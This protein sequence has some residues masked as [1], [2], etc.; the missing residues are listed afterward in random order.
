VALISVLLPFR[1]AAPT[2]PSALRSLRRQTHRQLEVVAV[3]DGSS[4]EG[5]DLVR[6]MARADSRLRLIRGRGVGLPAALNLG[7]ECCRG[8]FVARM[9]ADDISCARRLA[10]QLQFLEHHSR[11]AAA[12]CLVRMVPGQLIT[13]GMRRYEAWLNGL[14]GSQQIH[15]DLWV[16][17][18]LCHPS[19][20][21]RTRWLRRVGGYRAGDWPEDYDLWLRLVAAGAR[22]GKVPRTLLLWRESA[23]RLSRSSTAYS[24][25]QFFQLKLQH[26]RRLLGR[27]R[28]LARVWGA[29]QEGKP[30]LQALGQDGLLATPGLVVDVDPRKLG[31]RIHGCR[32]IAP[33]ELPP[34]SPGTLLL[35]A[36]GAPGAR[37]LIRRELRGRG[38]V[39]LQDFVCVA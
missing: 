27:Q 11:L 25:R 21:L 13:D 20:M 18:P 6:R 31:Q 36:V 19:V 30:W 39:E 9:D 16:E 29:G 5:P 12:G 4:D 10:C 38:W 7:L 37:R 23:G 24:R 28:R 26:L 2:L 33:P 35:V 22:L 32:V 14:V 17:S 1:D 3:D 15:R 34:P 8:P